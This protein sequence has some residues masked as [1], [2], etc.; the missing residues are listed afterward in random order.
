[1]ATS[2][3]FSIGGFYVKENK[4]AVINWLDGQYI[5]TN[6]DYKEVVTEYNLTVAQLS[7]KIN[8]LENNNSELN[9]QKN[10]LMIKVEELETQGSENAELIA[11]YQV[12]I[13]TLTEQLEINEQTIAEL[14]AL[15]DELCANMLSAIIELPD[16]L[17]KA[18]TLNFVSAG[19]NNFFVYV[20]N[21]NCYYFD[22]DKG[23][24]IQLSIP[25]FYALSNCFKS[26][27]GYFMVT[28]INNK[29][30]IYLLNTA[31]YS[32]TEIQK[33][34]VNSNYC[35]VSKVEN[36]CY[37]INYEY[38]FYYDYLTGEKTYFEV[39]LLFD[40]YS[41]SAYSMCIDNI[42][43]WDIYAHSNGV[44]IRIDTETKD[45]KCFQAP[46]IG[47]YYNHYLYVENG[48]EYLFNH[49]SYNPGIYKLNMDTLTADLV[50]A[51]T[52]TS[53]KC[54]TVFGNKLY[55]VD[56]TSM[57]VIE[58]NEPVL[59][60]EN[61]SIYDTPNNL[62]YETEEVEVSLI[63]GKYI[64]KHTKA[65]GE[66]EILHELNGTCRSGL[67][68][69]DS[70]KI[71]IPRDGGLDLYNT[72]DDSISTIYGS[73]FSS[74]VYTY[75]RLDNYLV[76]TLCTTTE[77]RALMIDVD[78]MNVSELSVWGYGVS[79]FELIDI[80]NDTAYIVGDRYL[81]IYSIANKNLLLNLQYNSSASIPENNIF[82]SNSYLTL[83]NG[84]KVYK[85]YVINPDNLTWTID[86][87][88]M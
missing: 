3:L 28:K 17:K 58:N 66:D 34:T 50:T 75:S 23:S 20:Q 57:Y 79:N 4:S 67:Y 78:T 12:Q 51:L 53:F 70:Q 82:Y 18:S 64:M 26:S 21:G 24:L 44:I 14:Q 7:E 42:I 63:F 54:V 85:R 65:T 31:D 40:I 1:M 86:M 37:F 74:S 5:V 36:G 60:R 46:Q 48:N 71:L 61:V 38:V 81:V 6:E 10:E 41:S 35:L 47:G 87:V 83:E 43:Y 72:V 77:T 22:Y 84:K 88:I 32:I 27:V 13:E 30:D 52:F 73:K 29:Y 68:H 2:T 56:G 45:F 9:I 69:I 15:I 76:I 80:Y 39:D 25:S 8:E 49:S 16:D 11:E 19:D 62:L 33:A 55:Y 59:Y